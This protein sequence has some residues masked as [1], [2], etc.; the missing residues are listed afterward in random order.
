MRGR[1]RELV[2]NLV[3]V[4]VAMLRNRIRIDE[5]GKNAGHG[6]VQRL[7]FRAAHCTDVFT[8]RLCEC[9]SLLRADLPAF[10]LLS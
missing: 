9:I 5:A 2:G 7:R 3:E 8:A 6:Q 4:L 1:F 10:L